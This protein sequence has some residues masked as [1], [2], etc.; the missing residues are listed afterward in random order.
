[1]FQ[2]VY[3]TTTF[4]YVVLTILLIRGALLDGSLLGIRYYLTP[5]WQKLREPK[6]HAVPCKFNPNFAGCENFRSNTKRSKR[7]LSKPIKEL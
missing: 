7:I 3:F 6:V 2:V 1:M 4:P 5:D